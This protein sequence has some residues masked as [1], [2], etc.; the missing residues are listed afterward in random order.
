MICYIL[1]IICKVIYIYM[2]VYIIRSILHVTYCKFDILRIIYDSIYIYMMYSILD[3]G[4][5]VFDMWCYMLY[6]IYYMCVMYGML[7]IGS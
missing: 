1:D 5:Y 6:T 3:I 2:S 7:P 4:G